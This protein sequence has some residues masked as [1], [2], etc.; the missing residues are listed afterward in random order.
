[1]S[2]QNYDPMEHF[3]LEVK[4]NIKSALTSINVD[5]PIILE[6]PAPEFGDFT[7][8]CFNLAPILKKS[9]TEIALNLA[10]RLPT[11]PSIQSEVK[12]PYINFKINDPL[13]VER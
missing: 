3:R 2:D 10:S 4:K 12:G 9:P 8:P 6:T 11:H 5:L 7:F 13:L 1:M